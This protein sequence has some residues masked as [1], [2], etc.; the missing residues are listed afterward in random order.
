MITSR[1]NPDG[2]FPNGKAQEVIHLR[3]GV[4]QRD[5][6]KGGRPLCDT[7]TWN[8]LWTNLRTEV[9]CPTCQNHIDGDREDAYLNHEH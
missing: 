3:I 8:L 5:P 2:P 7:R 4:D 6:R 1:G 9:T